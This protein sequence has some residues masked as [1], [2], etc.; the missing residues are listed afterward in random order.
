MTFIANRVALTDG[1]KLKALILED[2]R[3]I[4]VFA[5]EPDPG[6]AQ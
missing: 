2:G 1:G 3:S 5:Y 4:P 6:Q